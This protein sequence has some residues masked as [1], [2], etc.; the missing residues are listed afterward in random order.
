MKHQYSAYLCRDA[1]TLTCD[2]CAFLTDIR[3]E[4]SMTRGTKVSYFPIGLHQEAANRLVIDYESRDCGTLKITLAQDG[5]AMQL[6]A[7]ATADAQDLESR[8]FAADH[9]LV[10]YYASPLASQETMALHL[11]KDIWWQDIH[12]GT[13][14]AALPPHTQSL[15]MKMND[16]HYHLFPLCCDDFRTE[17]EGNRLSMSIGCGGHFSVSGVFLAIA[18]AETPYRAIETNIRAARDSGAIRVPLRNEKA[19]PALF[20]GFGWCTW[21]AFY[22]R[23]SSRGIFEKL[24][25]C[26]QKKIPLQW[27]LI[28]DGWSVTRDGKLWC[29]EEDR[30]KFPEGL[31]AVIRRI[32][33]EYGVRYVGVWHTFNGYWGGIHPDSPLYREQKDN[34][35][36][37]PGGQIQPDF[38]DREKCFS[39][40]DAWHS[41]LAGCGVDFVKVDNQSSLTYRVDGIMENTR[42]VRLAHEGLEKSVNL[43]FGGHMINCM[44]T[45]MIDIL[46]RPGSVTN[47]SSDDFWPRVK[48]SF[49]T[50]IRQNC[51]ASLVYAQ[52]HVCDFDMWWTDHESAHQSAVL[53]AISGG[54]VYVSDEVGHTNADRIMPLLDA[55]RHLLR[56]DG[57]A[58]VTLD[59]VY[60]DCVAAALPLKIFNRSGEN[61]AV[62][63]YALSE[64]GVNGVLRLEDLPS[65]G[66]EYVVHEYF[67]GETFRMDRH[68]RLPISL[69]KN[70]MRL[71]NLYPVKDGRAAVGPD[72]KYMGCAAA[73]V[74]VI[75]A[76]SL[77]KI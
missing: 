14:P 31:D 65:C 26:R 37:L 58:A 5:S 6:H 1:L 66:E 64:E 60:T 71:W 7:E 32:K 57:T 21:D 38:R 74:A 40:W 36:V 75:D 72:D 2:G 33:E 35:I 68:S 55:D 34:L 29:F 18:A 46:T 70:D 63:A 20:D 10:M 9:S 76:A 16:L 69:Q 41:Y 8:I 19:F 54:P 61:F 22:T 28:D 48:G 39:F 67:T 15:H 3:F 77:P 42:G 27:L 59:C 13:D 12:F 44:G 73:P 17:L 51:Y 23:V 25:E 62:A 49:V 53:R 4:A 56:C 45:N 11:K 50:H 52:F 43:H 30:E 24:E 47:R